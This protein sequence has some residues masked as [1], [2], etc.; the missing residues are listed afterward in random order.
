MKPHTCP[1][2]EP[3]TV[4]LLA[5]AP[6]TLWRFDGAK[7]RLQPRRLESPALLAIPDSPCGWSDDEV[8]QYIRRCGERHSIHVK[9]FRAMYSF[10]SQTAVEPCTA[11]GAARR[12]FED[13]TEA[14]RVKVGRGGSNVILQPECI[15][16][17]IDTIPKCFI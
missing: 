15:I 8:N 14:K 1:K 17:T 10:M 4:Q 11:K 2:A 16:K 5:P 6:A 3:I 7:T 12:R 9:G 13:K